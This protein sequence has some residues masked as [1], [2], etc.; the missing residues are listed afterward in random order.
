M[1]GVTESVKVDDREVK[2]LFK[3][4]KKQGEDM[5]PVMRVIGEIM[6]SS[7]VKNFEEGGRPRWI[8]SRKSK[9]KTLIKTSRLMSSINSM[10]SKI[11]SE[12][13]TNAVYAAIHQFGFDGM[14]KITA[15][16][17][18]VKSRDIKEGR[19]TIA[20]GIGFVRDHERMMKVPAR[21]F[22]MVQDEDM[23]EIRQAIAAH[24]MAAE[25]GGR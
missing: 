16:R 25:K 22:L 8:P 4:L 19:K 23:T 3:R 10:A 6:R 11:R 14:V 17:R 9:G 21:P 5:T 15:H 13:G 20:R 18:K 2:D 7:A 1:G 24:I 12:T